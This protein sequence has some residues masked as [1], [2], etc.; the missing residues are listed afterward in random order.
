MEALDNN[1]KI[2]IRGGKRKCKYCNTKG[3]LKYFKGNKNKKDYEL[4]ACNCITHDIIRLYKTY[5][6]EEVKQRIDNNEII[7][8]VGGNS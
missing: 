3:Y 6:P 8:Y 1:E 7:I 5:K 4:S 2:L